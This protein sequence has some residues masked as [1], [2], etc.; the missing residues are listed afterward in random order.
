MRA[1]SGLRA[2]APT[3]RWQVLPTTRLRPDVQALI[4]AGVVAGVKALL[5]DA[6]GLLA[7]A[8]GIE[9]SGCCLCPAAGRK[10]RRRCF[11]QALTYSCWRVCRRRGFGCLLLVLLFSEVAGI[12]ASGSCTGR[13]CCWQDAAASKFGQL[14]WPAALLAGS[15]SSRLRAFGLADVSLKAVSRLRAV[16]SANGC[17][18]ALLASRPLPIRRPIYVAT[19][20]RRGWDGCICRL[21]APGVAGVEA[22]GSCLWLPGCWRLLP[23]PRHPTCWRSAWASAHP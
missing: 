3:C 23:T 7:D 21:A 22:S 2:V 11:G 20:R 10:C 8:G 5:A 18:Q 16:A 9:A 12:E 6:S 4:F 14:H 17:W 13:H 15:P 19:G 1:A